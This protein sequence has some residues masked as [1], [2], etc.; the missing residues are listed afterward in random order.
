M[1]WNYQ[2]FLHVGDSE[3]D[4]PPRLAAAGQLLS[5]T[6]AGGGSALAVVGGAGV[7]H[8]LLL[9]VQPGALYHQERTESRPAK[10]LETFEVE[11]INSELLLDR[12]LLRLPERFQ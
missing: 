10:Q 4:R 5:Q 12:P 2:I 9:S 11:A 3:V 7:A 1:C 6:E 8:Q